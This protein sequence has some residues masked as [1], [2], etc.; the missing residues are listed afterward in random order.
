VLKPLQG[1]IITRYY[2]SF[3]LELPIPNRRRG[4]TIRSVRFILLELVAGIDMRKLNSADFSP[5]AR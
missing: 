4:V 5:E 1:T 3:M 2:G